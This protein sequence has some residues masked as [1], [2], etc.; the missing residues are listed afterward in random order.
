M[1]QDWEFHIRALLTGPRYTRFGRADH[2]WRQPEAERDSIG[3]NTMRPEMLAART[4]VNERVY[5]AVQAAGKMS[6]AY[7]R[8]FAGLFFQSAERIGTRISWRSGS[9]L[10]SR[11]HELGLIDRRQHRQGKRYFQ[12]FRFK[13][14]RGLYR[15]HLEHVWPVE[16]FARRS[17]T[18]LKTPLPPAMEAAA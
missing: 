7:R 15:K 8:Y 17:A 12:L 3:K 11:A 16:F 1:G 6:D 5:H 2:Y 18:Y 13:R 14:I 9:A 10:W 4:L